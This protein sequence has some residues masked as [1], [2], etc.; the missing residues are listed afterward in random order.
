MKGYYYTMNIVYTFDDSYFV[1][2]AVSISS[3]LENNK[4]VG[5]LKLF[6]VDCGIR[7]ENRRHLLK[8]VKRYDRK[9]FF[10]NSID[11]SRK[12]PIQLDTAFWSDVC[13]V[14]LFFAELMPHINK[15]IHID[16]D[17]L[18]LG[19]IENVYNMDMN[20]MVCS[21]CYDCIPSPK[22]AAGFSKKTE[23][24]SNGFLIFDLLKIRENNIQQQ[25]I[26]YIISK[27]GKLPHLDQDV[28]NAVL[29]NKINL[30]PQ[31]YNVMTITVMFG[32]RCCEMFSKEEK[33]YSPEEVKDAVK[34][35]MVLHF[36]GYRFVNRPWKQPC[37]HPY[38]SEWLNF[39]HKVDFCNKENLLKNEQRNVLK[40]L[41]CLIW[42]IGYKIP[43]IKSWEF[44]IEKIAM[45]RYIKRLIHKL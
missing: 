40:K 6:I 37:Y 11:I 3:L 35:P 31:K 22:Y 21:A 30:L 10:L 43:T 41:I 1:I 29:K 9:L 20:G 8:I 25:F 23:Y 19:N 44:E 34:N 2:A 45:K 4:E 5:E 7:E 36:V 39:Y 17:T 16:C 38:N 42:N 26:D 24:Y 15:V 12:I 13:Y 14:R 33:Y 32:D 27:H 28:I 18:V